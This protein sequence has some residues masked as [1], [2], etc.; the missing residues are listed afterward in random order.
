M[1]IINEL[2]NNTSTGDTN[3]SP[4]PLLDPFI[5]Q[6]LV[7]RGL[8]FTEIIVHVNAYLHPL[9]CTSSITLSLPL[10]PSSPSFVFHLLFHLL[11][12]MSL[13]L[14]IPVFL[15]LAPPLL[16]PCN[17]PYTLSFPLKACCLCSSFHLLLSCQ[18]LLCTSCFLLP[19]PI[20][21]KQQAEQQPPPSSSSS[22]S[23]S[24]F[25]RSRGRNWRSGRAMLRA[26]QD[27]FNLLLLLVPD[28]PSLPPFAALPRAAVPSPPA[29]VPPPG[30]DRTHG[31]RRCALAGAESGSRAG[32]G[33]TEPRCSRDE[34]GPGP[35]PG[36]GAGQLSALQSEPG[37]GFPAAGRRGPRVPVP[38]RV[39]GRGGAGS[40][41]RARLP[42]EPR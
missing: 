5:H 34:P 15:S 20:C 13:H 9:L 4:S 1:K 16:S 8:D 12:L 17:P 23:L 41:R 37:A 21:P 40:F 11:I 28:S 38:V 22:S 6:D 18:D 25:R 32:P 30:S 3:P 29:A 36:A 33:G 27:V 31:A 19:S 24:V 2:I 10:F 35:G 7:P 14:L 42:A 39:S 26:R